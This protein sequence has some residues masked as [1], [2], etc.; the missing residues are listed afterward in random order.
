MSTFEIEVFQA[1]DGTKYVK[2]ETFDKVLKASANLIEDM[3]VALRT[4]DKEKQRSCMAREEKL[5]QLWN[6]YH[7]EYP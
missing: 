5:I 7:N 4:H 2:K 1:D 3:R 6:Q